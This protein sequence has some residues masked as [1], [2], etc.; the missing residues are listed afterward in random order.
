MSATEAGTPLLDG[1][2]TPTNGQLRAGDPTSIA[3]P[4]PAS[5]SRQGGAPVPYHEAR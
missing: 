5:R 4:R 2:A 1:A 3:R